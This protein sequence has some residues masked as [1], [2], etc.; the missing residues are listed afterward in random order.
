MASSAER[1]EHPNWLD[2]EWIATDAIGQVAV[3]T[4]GGPGPI[5]TWLLNN[6]SRADRVAE[7]L[8]ELPIRGG[9]ELLIAAPRPDDFIRFAQQGLFSYDWADVAR[10]SNKSGMY[11]ICSRPEKPIVAVEMPVS[12]RVL[13]EQTTFSNMRFDQA[14]FIDVRAFIRCEP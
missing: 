12:C 7:I 14:S 3:F 5:P 4:T 2:Y 1:P 9:H 11:E 13:L 6:R 10:T 8:D